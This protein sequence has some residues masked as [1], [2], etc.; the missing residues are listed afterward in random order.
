[1]LI[2]STPGGL[3]EIQSVLARNDIPYFNFDYSIQSFVRVLEKF[4]NDKGAL[5]AVLIFQS[6]KDAKEAVGNFVSKPTMRIIILND[7]SPASTA[8]LKTLRPTPDFY[9]ILA[10]T[11]SMESLF[12]GVSRAINNLVK[13]N[14]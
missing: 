7:L 10:N 4:L 2:D 1:M 6:E 8:R 3:L 5:D 9:A 12:R 11:I 13:L 14:S